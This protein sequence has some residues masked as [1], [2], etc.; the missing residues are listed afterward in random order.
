MLFSVQ[1][2]SEHDSM[3]QLP[4]PLQLIVQ[5]PPAHFRFVEPAPVDVA[6]HPP[7]GQS[8]LHEPVPL[9]RKL[10]PLP[11][12]ASSQEP[13]P[14]HVHVAP[15]AHVFASGFVTAT[16]PLDPPDDPP[17]EDV[18]CV[19]ELPPDE[20]VSG[21]VFLTLQATTKD[22]RAKNETSARIMAQG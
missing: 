12:Q 19:P 13:T 2:Q 9:Q 18:V 7:C 5:S 20:D 15:T 14:S 1:T 11:A 10:Q 21:D 8:R 16:E 6:V 17:D 3:L 4:L 22:E